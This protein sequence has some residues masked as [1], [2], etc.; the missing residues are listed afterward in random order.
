MLSHACF[1]QVAD[2]SAAHS[3]LSF[4]GFGSLLRHLPRLTA[5]ITDALQ[6][7]RLDRESLTWLQPYQPSL[8][9]SWLYQRSMGLAPGHLRGGAHAGPV[10][11]PADHVNRLLVCNFAVMRVLGDGFMRPFLQVITP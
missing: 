3:P 10:Q 7:D 1:R 11:L 2:A 5:G 4:G 9:C 8:S 6:C